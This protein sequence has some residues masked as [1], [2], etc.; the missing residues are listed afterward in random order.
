[1]RT[2]SSTLMR[3]DARTAEMLSS[4]CASSVSSSSSLTWCHVAPR[5]GLEDLDVVVVEG[6]EELFDLTGFGVGDAAGDVLL[7]EVALLL[8]AGDELPRGLAVLGMDPDALWR[9]GLRGFL[10]F[11]RC[12]GHSYSCSIHGLRP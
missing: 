4:R 2:G 1:M 3:S 10:L 6:D 8:P 7:G 11:G 12:L 5:S 9:R